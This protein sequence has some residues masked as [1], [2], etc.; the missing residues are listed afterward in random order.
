MRIRHGACHSEHDVERLRALHHMKVRD[1]IA[2]YIRDDVAADILFHA[3][4]VAAR[5]LDLHHARPCLRSDIGDGAALLDGESGRRAGGRRRGRVVVPPASSATAP[6]AMTPPSSRRRVPRPPTGDARSSLGAA[7]AGPVRWRR[8]RGRNHE[9]F[10]DG[11]LGGLPIETIGGPSLAPGP[12]VP[13]AAHSVAF[14]NYS[15]CGHSGVLAILPGT[16]EFSPSV[17]LFV[18]RSHGKGTP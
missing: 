4:P 7:G 2:L 11:F 9:G 15:V 3:P 1:D 5:T 6:P 12:T 10:G 16:E 8:G 17:V 18:S 14:S 13:I